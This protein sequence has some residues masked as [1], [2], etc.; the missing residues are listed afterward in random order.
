MVTIG[1]EV[2]KKLKMK[3]GKTVIRNAH[4][5]RWRPIAIDNLSD[6]GDPINQIKMLTKNK[7]KS[8]RFSNEFIFQKI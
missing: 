3:T 6:S 4:N 8:L 2:F 1:I 5:N 7:N